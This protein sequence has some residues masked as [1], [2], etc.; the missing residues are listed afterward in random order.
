[1]TLSRLNL[2]AA[3]IAM[4]CAVAILWLGYGFEAFVWAICSL[5]WVV[6]ALAKSSGTMKEQYPATRLVRRF[7]RLLLW[8]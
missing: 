7:G 5:C 4:V 6:V 1:M 8:S 2:V 3:A